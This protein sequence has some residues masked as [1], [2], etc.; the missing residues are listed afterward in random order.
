M[1]HIIQ[2]WMLYI[3]EYCSLPLLENVETHESWDGFLA[4]Q[5][6]QLIEI[7][8]KIGAGAPFTPKAGEALRF[9]GNDI[10]KV[11][12]VIIGQ[13][14]YPQPGAATGRSFE[15]MGLTSSEEKF[16]Q[17]SLKN[18][19]RLI[20]ELDRRAKGA[21]PGYPAPFSKVR[22]DIKEGAFRIAGPGELF[23]RWEGQG[24]LLLNKYLTCEID[25]P[26]SHREIWRDFTSRAIEYLSVGNASIVW[27][28]WGGDARGSKAYIK[29]GSIIESRHPMMCSPGYEDDFL[30]SDCFS[31]T[32]HIIDWAGGWAG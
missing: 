32:A 29:G 26:G 5:H 11:K 28:L 8:S 21:R 30:K 31:R 4:A 12:A 3:M 10:S 27:M 24:V 25:K 9:M 6:T 13:D 14:P 15:V 18:I 16:R 2:E 19:V 20:H 7:W 1:L 23:R 22:E 17:V